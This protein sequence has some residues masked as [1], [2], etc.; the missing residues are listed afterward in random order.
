M[1][2]IVKLVGL[3]EDEDGNRWLVMQPVGSLISLDAPAAVMIEAL[4]Q[5]AT[6]IGDLA[7]HNFMHGDI[8]HNNVLLAP[9]DAASPAPE[10]KVFL[11]DFGTGRSLK[12]VLP[13]TL[14]V[15]QCH[16]STDGQNH[17]KL[18]S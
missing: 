1:P 6:T 9:S 15:L 11:I 2:G 16:P 18:A 12:Q 17:G 3:G 5:M 13:A 7:S 4:K 8:S 10:P 14:D